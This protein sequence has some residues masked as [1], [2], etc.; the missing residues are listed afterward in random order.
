MSNE[1]REELIAIEMALFPEGPPQEE[2]SIYGEI[3][4][5]QRERKELRVARA[6]LESIRKTVSAP[7]LST[8]SDI[9]MEVAQLLSAKEQL[10]EE[11]RESIREKREIAQALRATEDQS[12]QEH[13]RKQAELM[14]ELEAA[15]DKAQALASHYA[16]T[17]RV[18]S[19]LSKL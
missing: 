3:Y 14:S 6:A 17:M 4:T 15:R 2:A 13:I 9:A 7:P 5:L 19:H 18:I 12:L 8:P 10:S 1:D 11:L 16:D